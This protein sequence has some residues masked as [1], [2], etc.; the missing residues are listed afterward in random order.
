MSLEGLLADFRFGEHNAVLCSSITALQQLLIE[1]CRVSLNSNE[2]LLILT[3]YD[4]IA[5]LLKAQK[6]ID[7][8]LN[9][10]QHD[11]SLVIRDCAKAYFNLADELVDI[12]IMIRMLLQRKRKLSKDGLTV[13]CDMEIFF[14]K[15]RIVDFTSHEASLSLGSNDFSEVRMICCYVKPSLSLLTQQQSQQI[16][17]AHTK[18]LA[19]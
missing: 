7:S 11:G 2:I 19:F 6:V 17:R 3:S 4:S 10:R 13:I 14:H 8:K 18:I 1:Y 15:N 12:S 16:L 5:F 9:S